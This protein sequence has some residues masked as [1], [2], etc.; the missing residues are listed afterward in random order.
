MP[1]LVPWSGRGG[2]SS[3]HLSSNALALAAQTLALRNHLSVENAVLLCTGL[4]EFQGQRKKISLSGLRLNCLPLGTGQRAELF[5]AVFASVSGIDNLKEVH[6]LKE[7]SLKGLNTLFIAAVF[8]LSAGAHALPS[9]LMV[10]PGRVS[11]PISSGATIGGQSGTEF[12][13]LGVRAESID[14]AGERLTLSYGDRFGQP[15]PGEPGFFHVAVDRDAKRIVI[16]LAQITKTAIDPQKLA[17]IL[18]ASK[19]IASSEMTMD[20][21]DGSTN[22]TLNLKTPVQMKVASVANG[23][24]QVVI[25]LVP[26]EGNRK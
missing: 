13:L 1:K 19:L 5:D 8:S 20:P 23:Q 3:D 26:V 12:S 6:I 25:D 11:A 17:R 2:F 14:R 22:I 16:D 7:P 24:A 18:S 21:Q 9:P 10:K 4:A 15:Q